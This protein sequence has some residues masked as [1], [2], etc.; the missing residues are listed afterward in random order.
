MLFQETVQRSANSMLEHSNLI[1]KTLFPSELLPISVFFSS[2][3]NHLLAVAL[4]V[5]AVAFWDGHFY[6]TLLFLP[7][8]TGFLGMLA[9]GI[10]WVF[11]SLQVYL[12]DTAQGVIVFLTLWF[13]ATP[14][15]IS[16]SQV[17]DGVRFILRA[18]P[19][20]LFVKAYRARLL[21]TDLPHRPELAWSAGWSGGAFLVGGMFFRHLKRGFA[22][23]L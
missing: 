8:Y 13:W 5:T 2:A 22:D 11:A 1:T 16:E 9:V 19:L 23:V 7:L 15:F 12:R 3:L 14:I 6:W 4:A 21:S 10:G 18:N 20:S 17:P